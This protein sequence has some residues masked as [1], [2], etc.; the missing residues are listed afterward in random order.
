MNR[1]HRDQIDVTPPATLKAF[2]GSPRLQVSNIA[3]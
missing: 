1:R 3:M 2:G